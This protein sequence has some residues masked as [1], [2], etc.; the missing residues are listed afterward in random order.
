MIGAYFFFSNDVVPKIKEELKVTHREAMIEAGKRWA[1]I[2]D[3]DKEQYV[4]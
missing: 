2:T 1:V 3:K 4:K